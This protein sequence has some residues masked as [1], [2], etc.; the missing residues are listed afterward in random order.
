M[1]KC[2]FFA[3]KNNPRNTKAHLSRVSFGDIYWIMKYTYVSEH[4]KTA[5]SIIADQQNILTLF[6][7]CLEL[8]RKP[9]T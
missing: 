9:C 5:F 8:R 7:K 3:D 1:V 4:I 6:H 2:T